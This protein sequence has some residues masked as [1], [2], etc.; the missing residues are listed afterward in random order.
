M[1][2]AQG[3][4]TYNIFPVFAVPGQILDEEF[5]VIGS[6]CAASVIN[7]GTAVEL[8]SDGVSIQ[9]VQDTGDA[10]LATMVGVALLQT[11][12]EGA[13]EENLTTS[14]GGAP[15]Q[16]GDMVQVMTRGKVWGFWSGTTQVDLSIP[17]IKHSSTVATLRG[18]FTDAV[19]SAS[20]GS[21]VSVGPA[22]INVVQ[23]RAGTGNVVALAVNFPGKY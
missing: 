3:Q 2:Y 23:V 17:N 6:Y 15:W 19:A 10:A 7:P 12:R 20:T 8:A 9:M 13:G 16:P 21:E 22:W 4:T 11:A 1:T 18:A 14:I 5:N